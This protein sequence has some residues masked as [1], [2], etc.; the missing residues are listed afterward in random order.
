MA[1]EKL[2]KL[3]REPKHVPTH[4]LWDDF[5]VAFFFDNALP[6]VGGVVILAAATYL[7]WW[8]WVEFF[9]R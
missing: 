9:V 5:R 7:C 2:L 4:W 8:L 3:Y 1:A 6:F